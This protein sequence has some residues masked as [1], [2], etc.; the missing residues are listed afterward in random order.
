M[1]LFSRLAR[2]KRPMFTTIPIHP[3]AIAIT[4]SSSEWWDGAIP[5]TAQSIYK[6]ILTGAADSESDLELPMSALQYRLYLSGGAYLSVVVPN[7]IA[8]MD[9]VASRPNGCLVV[10]KGYRYVDGSE[11]IAEMARSNLG[12]IRADIGGRSSSLTL[13][14]SGD[15]DFVF[16]PSVDKAIADVITYVL[17]ADG[18]RKL[19]VEPI[20]GMYPGDIVQ[21]DGISYLV[22][23]LSVSVGRYQNQM[24]LKFGAGEVGTVYGLKTNTNIDITG[25]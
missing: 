15:V 12:S 17:Q 9:A 19:R 14:G 24:E 18:K 23:A 6:C 1:V 7:A 22:E 11:Q 4:G 20:F 25:F 2:H 8:Y 5:Y 10:Y 3:P 21:Y 16:D 13:T